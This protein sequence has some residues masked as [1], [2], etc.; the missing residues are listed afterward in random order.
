MFGFNYF[1]WTKADLKDLSD[2]DVTG[3]ANFDDIALS[4]AAGGGV[5]VEF[6]EKYIGAQ[7]GQKAYTFRLYADFKALYIYGGEAG[8]IKKGSITIDPDRKIIYDISKS[9]T[10]VIAIYVGIVYEM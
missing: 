4:Y 6:Y 5:M 7:N 8:F 9:E 10:D 2:V 1:L 3:K